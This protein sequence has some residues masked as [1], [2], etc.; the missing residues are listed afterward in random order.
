MSE[1]NNNVPMRITQLEEAETFDYE[2]YIA[3]A[4]AGTGTKKVKGSTLLAELTDIRVGADS[5]TYPSA[6]DAVRSQVTNLKSDINHTKECLIY[7]YNTNF[8]NVG[9]NLFN[10]YDTD[11]TTSGYISRTNELVTDSDS[12]TSGFIRVL[13]NHNYA[14][15]T[16]SVA[17]GFILFYTT[18]DTFYGYLDYALN[19]AYITIPDGVNYIRL[20]FIKTDISNVMVNEGTSVGTYEKYTALLKNENIPDPEYVEEASYN[21]FDATDSSMPTT[22]Y[23]DRTG[24]LVTNP[25]IRSTGFISV[26]S[27][28]L[29]SF[30]HS[31]SGYV[32]W[33]DAEKSF[34]SYTDFTANTANVSAPSGASYA[35]FMLLLSEL[36]TY[37]VNEGATLQSYTKYRNTSIKESYLENEYSGLFGV[38]FGTS[39]TYRSQTT[40]GYLQYLPTMSKIVFDNKG[41]G[42]S[43][44]LANG[45]QPSMLPTI[46]SYASFANKDICILE[47][48]VNDWYYNGD[49]LGTWKDTGT[50][51]VCGCVRS[52]LSHILTQNANITIFLILDHFG[53]GITAT[54]AVNS[55]GQTQF[56]FYQEIEKVALSMGIRVIREYEISEISE[57][58]P[59]YLLDNIHLNKLGAKQSAKAIWSV[60]KQTYP[61]IISN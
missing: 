6:G 58:T 44:I 36:E 8:F 51:T 55:E 61:N 23:Y 50:T 1:S 17:P 14:S 20:A 45:T 19:T 21:L 49:S 26:K 32:L 53:K 43:V 48:F 38:A 18:K 15:S 7:P 35:R 56:E 28:S 22:G 33:Y 29:Y 3:N 9:T 10:Q 37:I 40:G 25:T 47:G 24:T 59:Q 11:V 39:L 2:S 41:I 27:G 4:K 5:T 34:L 16:F 54:T 60:M 30:T 13:P 42:S 31:Y 12:R 52:A 57:L 46:T